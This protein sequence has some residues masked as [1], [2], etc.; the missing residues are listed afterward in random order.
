MSSILEKPARDLSA[1]DYASIEKPL[2]ERVPYPGMGLGYVVSKNGEK[3]LT[4]YLG[5]LKKPLMVTSERDLDEVEGMLIRDM[6][7]PEMLKLFFEVMSSINPRNERRAMYLKGA[8]GAGKTFLGE[9]AGNVSSKKG[10]IK[11]DC[12]NMNL[13]ELFFETV[14]DFNANKSFYDALNTKIEKY[15]LAENKEQRDQVLNPMSIDILE[16]CLGN[17]FSEEN[18]KICIDWAGVKQA[19][20]NET[21][22][23]L[24]TRE[25]IEIA[26]A[27]LKQVS[28]KEGLD[29]LGGNALGMASQEGPAFQAY[30]E[31]RVLILDELN[32]AKR[33]TFGVLHGFMQ[34]AINE[35]S[36]CRVRNPLK[37]KGDHARSDLHFQRSKMGSGFFIFMTGN[38][39]DD[40]D[41]VLELPEALSSR[42]VP[43][44]VANATL[45]GWQHRWCQILTGMPISTLY[46]AQSHIWDEDPDVFKQ[47]LKEWRE[48][49]ETREIPAHQ[50][51]MLRRWQDVMQ[52]TGNLAKFMD[53]AS[54]TVNPDSNWHKAGTLTQLLDDISET[55][56]KEVSVDFRKINYFITKAM[57]PKPSVAP[58][59]DENGPDI[60]PLLDEMD[61]PEAPED[62][63]RNLGTHI[64]Y[65]ILDWIVAN[66]YERG[67][68]DLGNQLM[69]LAAD[70][71]LV[72][73]QLIEGMPS[74]R[75]TVAEL[76]DEN[77]FDSNDPDIRV[78]LIRDLLCDYLRNSYPDITA[79][80]SEIMPASVVRRAI[81]EIA[82][83]GAGP[84]V[85]NSNPDNINQEPLQKAKCI[86]MTP[87][88]QDEGQNEK[89]APAA[90]HLLSQY[91][92]LATLAAPEL[93]EHN[94]SCLWNEALSGSGVVSLGT[95][96]MTDESLAIAENKSETGVAATTI[97]VQSDKSENEPTELPLH[98]IWNK[99]MDRLLVV[100]EGEVNDSLKRAFNDA[101]VIYIDRNANNAHSTMR[102]GLDFVLGAETGTLC[103]TVRDAFL[104]RN[105]LPTQKA[106]TKIDNLSKML[107]NNDLEC[108]LP[109]YLAK[110]PPKLRTA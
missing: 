103:D 38:T 81:D 94:L 17:A 43:D 41:E 107:L 11:I 33:G 30:E 48:L 10:A 45:Q 96:G 68:E 9:M 63:K 65:V 29:N 28:A 93:R 67:K 58:P 24:D 14:L 78:E 104:M 5:V 57:M 73:P 51:N 27:G 77:P 46:N 75:K 40:S 95:E 85:F 21:G 12:T 16:D 37:E 84:V 54:K 90:D 25:N 101:R 55:F 2:G 15:N 50:L 53:A 34:F 71:A 42:V 39:E 1:E 62:I 97:I 52:A 8:P 88:L 7:T 79:E 86:D 102:K 105:T 108:F 64:T 92:L 31:G 36:E 109:H 99:S 32:R 60:I 70:C 87:Q 18:G 110:E 61:I 22:E 56:K 76:L 19:H 13:Y 83:K 49:R 72:D 66:S 106:E 91:A 4:R 74:N 47:K 23:R 20:S 6:P 80:N 89:M 3:K 100:G 26:I 44:P 69:Q 59:Q 82:E 98:V 35:I